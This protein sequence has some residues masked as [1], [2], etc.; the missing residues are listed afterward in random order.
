MEPRD[1][2][3]VGTL[4]IT[5]LWCESSL[6]FILIQ[7]LT[8]LDKIALNS[9]CRSHFRLF[10]ALCPCIFFPKEGHVTIC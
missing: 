2:H 9:V 5:E 4:S 8:K 10:L 7:G 1:L 6:H 3:M